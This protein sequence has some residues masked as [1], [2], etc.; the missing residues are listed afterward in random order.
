MNVQRIGM[1]LFTFFIATTSAA[2]SHHGKEFL[3]TASSRTPERGEWFGILS[4]DFQRLNSHISLEPGILYGIS[5]RWS[6]EIHAHVGELNESPHFASIGFE[7]RFFL[8]NGQRGGGIGSNALPVDIGL[9]VEYEKGLGHD[10]H[11]AIEFRGLISHINTN[12]GASLNLIAARSLEAGSELEY[13]YAVGVRSAVTGRLSAGL[14]M[15]GNLQELTESSVTP[16]LYLQMSHAVQLRVGS[17]IDLS[18][19]AEG[20]T[21]RASLVFEF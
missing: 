17:S 8:W 21:M 1:L 2:L 10:S 9:L 18:P 16:G 5:D 14:E 3:L 15:I 12:F 4:S 6:A 19:R 20:L 13:R 11:D 7:Q